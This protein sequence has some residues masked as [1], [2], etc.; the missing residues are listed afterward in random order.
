M[1]DTNTITVLY[2][3]LCGLQLVHSTGVIHRDIKPGNILISNDC[4]IKICDFGLSRIL[5]KKSNFQKDIKN[6]HRDVYLDYS[7]SA[8]QYLYTEDRDE[9]EDGFK[10][11]ITECL[12]KNK[13]EREN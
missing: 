6:I 10:Q 12:I 5:P 3:L 11:K 2:N 9:N 4:G 1:N 13:T 8:S 7:S